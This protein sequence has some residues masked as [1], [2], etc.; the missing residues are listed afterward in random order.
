[1][2]R[3]WGER[4]CRIKG[5]LSSLTL[6]DSPVL[7]R[8][9]TGLKATQRECEMRCYARANEYAHFCT[10]VLGRRTP[11]R[12]I[13]Y[14]HSCSHFVCIFLNANAELRRVQIMRI[15]MPLSTCRNRVGKE[16]RKDTNLGLP[17]SVPS[18]L[19][20][21]SSPP[22]PPF[23][24]HCLVTQ[25][26]LMDHLY[27]LILLNEVVTVVDYSLPFSASSCLPCTQ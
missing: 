15:P 14:C 22:C 25:C 17:P 2:Q 5:D 6:S 10:C 27:L 8:S 16:R 12:I 4:D 13:G 1:M 11:P 18:S 19:P 26:V 23:T 20:S 7:S 24:H 3:E 21:L 9:L